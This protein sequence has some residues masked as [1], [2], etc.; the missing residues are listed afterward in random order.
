MATLF[1]T[2]LAIYLNTEMLS[3]N[4]KETYLAFVFGKW[5]LKS[6]D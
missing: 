5:I 6:V 1:F 3:R 4:Y 2:E